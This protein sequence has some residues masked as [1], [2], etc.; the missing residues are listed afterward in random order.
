MRTTQK[1]VDIFYEG[2]GNKLT[3]NTTKLNLFKMRLH[4]FLSDQLPSIGH[5]D[6]Y[7]KLAV[8]KTEP[9]ISKTEPNAKPSETEEKIIFPVST[10]R[11]E[12]EQV[13]LSSKTKKE[14]DK[15]LL[16]L[17]HHELIY[18][19]WNLKKI[20]ANTRTSMN[21]YGPPGTGK[22]M[23]ADAIANKLGKNI[24]RLNYAQVESK[25]VGDAPKNVDAAFMQAEESNSVLFFDE[26]DSLLGKRMG[27][28][29]SGSEQAINSL[30][31]QM[32]IAIERFSGVVIFATNILSNYDTAFESR[33]TSIE[34]ALP[35]YKARLKI[36][37]NVPEELPTDGHV[38]FPKLAKQFDTFSGRDIRNA[39][40][41]AASN[42]LHENKHI[43]SQKHF[44]DACQTIHE[45]R[46]NKEEEMTDKEKKR[47][48]KKIKKAVEKNKNAP[49]E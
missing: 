33:I 16:L 14:I 43:L 32:L 45:T 9:K 39:I 37:E 24:M 40:M 47:M 30:R 20:M 27:S 26:A 4:K 21:F 15:S 38:S 41:G 5:T 10:P 31:S 7:I 25:Y 44:V 8:S 42:A 34:F 12:L 6:E 48:S 29:S 17:K 2:F 35:D 1:S 49:K 13:F 46:F 22:T 18:E 19:Q 28:V 11:W 23:C 3:S 36:W